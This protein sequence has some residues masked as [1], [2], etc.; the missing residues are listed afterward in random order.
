[1]TKPPNCEWISM[2]IAD[3]K[4]TGETWEGPTDAGGF[5]H[6]VTQKITLK[7]VITYELEIKNNPLGCKLNSVVIYSSNSFNKNLFVRWKRDKD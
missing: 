2:A 1:M 7:S 3:L 4:G 5:R 6:Q